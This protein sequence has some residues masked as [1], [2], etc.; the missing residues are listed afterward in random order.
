MELICEYESPK[1]ISIDQLEYSGGGSTI[2]GA[3][4]YG[5]W[6]RQ[7]RLAQPVEWSTG[8]VDRSGMIATHAIDVTIDQRREIIR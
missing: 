4:W 5:W 8:T 3:E 1:A 6:N 2:D 7:C